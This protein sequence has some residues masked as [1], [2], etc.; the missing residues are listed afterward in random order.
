MLRY[1]ADRFLLLPMPEWSANPIDPISIR[2]VLHYL[3]AVADPPDVPPA[4]AYDISGPDT[5]TYGDLLRTYART[6]GIWRTP[7]AV[8]GIDTCLVSRVSGVVLP[9]AGRP[10][11]RSH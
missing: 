1:V 10:G 3:V 2:D 8:Y 5:T 11:R 6:A 7:V 9:R 4:G